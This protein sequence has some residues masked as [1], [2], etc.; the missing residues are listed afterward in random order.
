MGR[1]HRYKDIIQAIQDIHTVYDNGT[2]VINYSIDLISGVPGLS[3]A[4]WIETLQEVTGSGITT[5]IFKEC[6]PKH[7][8]I[9]DLQIEEGTVFDKLYSNKK[10]TPRKIV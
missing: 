5:S 10:T 6:P 2:S 4:K 3:L 7:I 9:Y 1:Y 8:S